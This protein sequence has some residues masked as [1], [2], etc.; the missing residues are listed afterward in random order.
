LKAE[1]NIFAIRL[2][3]PSIGLKF[4]IISWTAESELAV[5]QK[6]DANIV[7]L[8]IIKLVIMINIVCF[9]ADT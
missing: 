9:P 1:L 8:N 3:F 5:V 2:M 7:F 4:L 6:L